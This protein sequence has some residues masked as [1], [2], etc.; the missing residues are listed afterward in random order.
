MS[1]GYLLA[2]GPDLA[3]AHEISA[4]FGLDVIDARSVTDLQALGDALAAAPNV[5]LLISAAAAQDTR[6]MAIMR[7]LAAR[8]STPQLILADRNAHAPFAF[9]PSQWPAMLLEDARAR[10]ARRR[11]AA[12]PPPPPP[13]PPFAR[14]PLGDLLGRAP[15]PS[16][17]AAPPPPARDALSDLL[18]QIAKPDPSAPQPHVPHTIATS[19]E[20]TAAPRAGLPVAPHLRPKPEWHKRHRSAIAARQFEVAYKLPKRFH[21]QTASTTAPPVRKTN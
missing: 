3:A 1:N 18:G 2:A 4:G 8:L 9:L 11:E 6:F 7:A 14:G 21:R 13:P 10:A 20:L 17:P 16:Q 19:P 12:P 5:G 15:T